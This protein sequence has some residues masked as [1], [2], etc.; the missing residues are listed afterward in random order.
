M[1]P[2]TYYR[3]D[4]GFG[5]GMSLNAVFVA[6]QA[7]INP[8]DRAVA[9]SGL[10][11]SIPIGSILGMAGCNAVMQGIMPADLALRLRSLGI[12]G[13]EAEKVTALLVPLPT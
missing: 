11:L 13:I 1:F 10:Y 4:S 3:R 6:L 7:A 5:T 9:A 2:F 12:E 8:V